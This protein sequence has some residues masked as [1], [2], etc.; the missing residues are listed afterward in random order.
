M[1]KAAL[2][3]DIR[4]RLV[5]RD[6]LERAGL[7]AAR[8]LS[9][10]GPYISAASVACYM[11][12]DSEPDV[13]YIS[14]MVLHDQKNLLLPRV[15]NKTDMAFYAVSSFS[16]MLPG[17][18]GILQPQGE[19]AF[20]KGAIEL[21]IIPALAIA[22]NGVR[23]GMG[24]GYYDRFLAGTSILTVAVVDESRLILSLPEEKHDQ[25]VNYYSVDGKIYPCGGK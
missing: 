17:P 1:D 5:S 21:M 3:R 24:G 6:A 18:F 20:D 2:R 10:F 22:P 11:P 16:D 4:A 15:L 8:A 19:T 14:R 13:S 9:T 25:R 7:L 12:M 23:L